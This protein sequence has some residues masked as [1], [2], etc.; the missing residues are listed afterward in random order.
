MVF[1]NTHLIACVVVAQYYFN[2]LTSNPVF[3]LAGADLLQ[4]E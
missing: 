4:T 3:K 2:F 1:L